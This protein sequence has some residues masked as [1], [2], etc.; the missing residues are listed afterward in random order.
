MLI[1]RLMMLSVSMVAPKFAIA[2]MCAVV[3]ELNE[4][5]DVDKVLILVVVPKVDNVVKMVGSV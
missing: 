1:N 5:M 4:S 3:V 2:V